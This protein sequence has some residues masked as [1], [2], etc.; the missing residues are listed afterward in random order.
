M[1]RESDLL[2]RL[3]RVPLFMASV[4]IMVSLLAVSL[5]ACSGTE[6]MLGTVLDP[7]G[8][9]PLFE[10]RDQFGQPVALADFKGKVVV[11]TFLYTYCD[12]ICPIVTSHLQRTYESLRA[13]ASEVAFVAISV[14][15]SRDTVERA[16]A[17]SQEWGML[18]RWAFLVGDEEQLSPIWKAYYID[19]TVDDRPLGG[20]SATGQGSG[21]KHG[22]VDALRQEMAARYQVTHSAPVY[23]ID[24]EGLMRVLFTLPLDPDEL[25]HDIA[26]LLD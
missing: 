23:L 1:R 18:D 14:D 4:A 26:L 5:S 8:P 7:A 17:Y 19:P 16:H 12:D 9:A 15:P 20:A 22:S 13:D 25:V 2:K 6:P 21:A 10:L 11:L 24:R 3:R